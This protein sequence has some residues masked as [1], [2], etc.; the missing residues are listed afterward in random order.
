MLY[1]FQQRLPILIGV[2]LL[3][4]MGIAFGSA[5][6]N[7]L[8]PA[9]ISDLNNYLKDF[10]LTLPQEL[11]AVNR[12]TL[13]A[14]AAADNILKLSGLIWV[15]G[16]TIIGVPVILGLIFVRGFVLGFTVGFMISELH[17]NGVLMAAASLL[18]HNL[19][20]IPALILAATTAISFAGSAV[21]TLIGTSHKSIVVHFLAT[22]IIILF[23]SGLLAVA[24]LV[25]MY[26]TPILMQLSMH[27]IA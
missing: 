19:F 24:S 13:A 22:T 25:E 7:T 16:L 9:Q 2:V 12:H 20:L 26:I 17:L 10:Y 23:S 1:Y 27:L 14:K 21:K 8:S 18:P 4:L 5:A 11:A 15:L 6:V 3:F